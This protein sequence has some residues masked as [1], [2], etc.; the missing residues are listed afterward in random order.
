MVSRLTKV[1]I[2][3][4]AVA[5]ATFATVSPDIP[6]AGQSE[7]ILK[8]FTV[9]R[10]DNQLATK[11]ITFHDENSG[12]YV[13]MNAHGEPAIPFFKYVEKT[14]AGGREIKQSFN[15]GMVLVAQTK[16]DMKSL[17]PENKYIVHFTQPLSDFLHITSSGKKIT[18]LT[19]V[20]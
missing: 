18:A 13:E 16:D 1:G 19:L 12:A 15:G 8:D 10:Q 2:A 14:K 5:L 3:F 7:L 6:I 20:Q 4:G 9:E 17:K 11:T